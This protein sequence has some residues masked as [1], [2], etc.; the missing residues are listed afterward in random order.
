MKPTPQTRTPAPPPSDRRP[1][2]DHREFP[3]PDYAF[4]AT[5][6]A[7]ASRPG[8]AA[9]GQAEAGSFRKISRSFM[10]SEVM[11]EYWTEALFF[12]W[13]SLTAS[14]PMGVLVNELTSMMIRY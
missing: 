10:E 9:R 7:V 2:A 13:I 5:L 1:A 14:W 6:G 4:Q 11:R 8:I 3:V 12:A